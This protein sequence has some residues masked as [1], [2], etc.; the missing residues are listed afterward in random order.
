MYCITVNLTPS[1][2]ARRRYRFG[3][4]RKARR[5]TTSRNLVLFAPDWSVQVREPSFRARGPRPLSSCAFQ[6]APILIDMCI[7]CPRRCPRRWGGWSGVRT[8]ASSRRSRPRA[9]SEHGPSAAARRWSRHRRR[10]CMGA[11][12]CTTKHVVRGS[13]RENFFLSDQSQ[14]L[15][16][17][18]RMVQK[19]FKSCEQKHL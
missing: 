1:P 13:K 7:P 3:G 19:T 4:L 2:C 11:P 6:N 9:R 8:R 10:R 5:L 12:R 15:G 17:R 18:C 16:E 14:D